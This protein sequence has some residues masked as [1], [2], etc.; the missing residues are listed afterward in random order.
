MTETTDHAEGI[1]DVLIVGGGPAGATAALYT[2]RAGL[3]TLVIDKGI[4]SGALGMT[5]GIANFPGIQG[6]PSGAEVVGSIRDQAAS[7]GARFVDDRVTVAEV[8]GDPKTLYGNRGAYRGQAVIVATGSM[9]RTATLP[10]EDALVGRGVSYCATCD[11]FFFA[12]QAV[13]VVGNTE[14]AIE[15][16]LYLTRF[17]R[18]VHLICP[19][20]SLR[21]SDDLVAQLEAEPK[22]E[23]RTA[24]SAREIH[25]ETMVEGLKI[26]RR[27]G[28]EETLPVAGVFIYLQGGAPII[29]FLNDQVPTTDAGCLLVDENFQTRVPGVFAAGDVLCKHL[30][31]AVIAAAEGAGAAVAA[32]RYLS[33]RSALKPDWA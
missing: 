31:Q 20:S 12:D 29:G 27:D 10:G 18:R 30:K 23:I 24:T 17:A 13:A 22:I 5:H 19:T 2:A 8:A 26:K 16:A 11:G 25:G 7:F 32:D 1:H 4:G 15:E 9:G 28:E 21:V 14:E 33:G 3:S 6:S